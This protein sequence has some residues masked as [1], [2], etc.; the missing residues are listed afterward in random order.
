MIKKMLGLALA[1]SM[2]LPV[3]AFAETEVVIADDETVVTVDASNVQEAT[4]DL[5]TMLEGALT[6]SK[7]IVGA[8]DYSINANALSVYADS[9]PSLS[10]LVSQMPSTLKMYVGSK[11]NV[12]EVEVSWYC[13]G[14]DYEASKGYYYQFSPKWDESKYTIDSSINV[15][16]DM[17]Y[18]PV[19]VVPGNADSSDEISVFHGNVTGKSAE[20]EVYAY[21]TGSMGLN[22]AA[23][24]GIMANIQYESSFRSD[25]WGDNGTSFG[26]CQWHAGRLT[27][28]KNFCATYGYDYTSVGGQLRFM[29]YELTGTYSSVYSRLKSVSDSG[30]GAYEA[31]YVWCIYYEIPANKEE[32]AVTRG[33]LGRNT[34]WPEYAGKST[35]STPTPTTTSKPVIGVTGFGTAGWYSY[36][37]YTFYLDSTGMPVTNKWLKI[38]NNWFYFDVRGVMATGLTR[39]NGATYLMANNGVM[40]TGWQKYNNK[41]YYLNSNGEA[42]KGWVV[43]DGKRY[44]FEDDCSMTA[45]WI[46]RDGKWYYLNDYTGQPTKGWKKVSGAWYYLGQ[47]DGAMYTGWLNDDEEWYYLCENGAMATG[48][49]K[50][51]DNWYYFNTSGM[52]CTGWKLVKGYWYYMAQSGEMLTGFI[53]YKGNKYFLN[54][55]G[56]MAT[57]WKYYDGNWYYFN[58]SGEMY[59]GW[60]TSGNYTY[61]TGSDGKMVTGWVMLDNKWCYFDGNG[62]YD[63]SAVKAE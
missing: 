46:K 2:A 60:L 61:Y 28:L 31:G 44:H 4:G 22:N 9:K 3:N 37:G 27:N 24:C 18:V 32:K 23:A 40:L 21:L 41:W 59:C 8:P 5:A 38:N 42:A 54:D 55:N 15:L 19:F 57:G 12:E 6:G 13:V 47:E 16:T 35:G 1:I 29:A 63:A 43:I 10:E 52:M 45:G 36:M 51:K 48:W 62:A 30:D 34:Y 50:V 25:I 11:D 7:V 26:L 33:N 53:N 20:D 56:D 17:P 58:Q 49:K 14:D 39:I